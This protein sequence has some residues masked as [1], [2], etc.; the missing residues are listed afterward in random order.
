MSENEP[1]TV[2]VWSDD[3]RHPDRALVAEVVAA[4]LVVAL[5]R[6]VLVAAWRWTLPN[7]RRID[8]PWID[9][10]RWLAIDGVFATGVFVLGATIGSFLNVVVHRLP[11]GRSPLS[12]RSHCPHCGHQIRPSDNIPV[13]GWLR[14]GGR[15][16]DCQA[17]ISPRYPIVEAVCGG[18][19]LLLWECEWASGGANLP[20]GLLL[21]SSGLDWLILQPRSDLAGSV[22]FHGAVLL[23]LV[24]WALV[25]ADGGRLPP[26]HLAAVLGAAVAAT[27]VWPWLHPVPLV[28]GTMPGPPWLS[29]GLAVALVGLAVGGVVGSAAGRSIGPSWWP[30]ACLALWGAACGW[31]AVAGTALVMAGL[32][33]ADRLAARS[34]PWLPLPAPWLFLASATI[35]LVAWRWIHAL[36]FGA[37]QASDVALTWC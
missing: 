31:Q 25:A 26:R 22:V 6:P 12:G 24:V 21:P 14:L 30:A 13:V 1:V 3:P 8:G 37:A 7:L 4:V 28:P 32:V 19:L 23:V 27:T 2:P 15:C 10:V 35:H 33:A 29:R 17:P 11:L 5:A 18:L 36:L 16:R 20:G 34:T 9:R